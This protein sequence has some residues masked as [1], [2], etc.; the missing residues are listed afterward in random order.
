MKK[1]I[2][3]AV[4]LLCALLVSAQK[5]PGKPK[6]K[7][8]PLVTFV[9]LG[10]V[11][12]VPCKMMKPVMKEIEDIYGEKVEVIFYDVGQSKHKAMGDKYKVRV[13]P[14]Q[15][16]L[17]KDGKEFHRHEGFYPKDEIVKLIDK[18]LGI[19]RKPSKK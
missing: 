8:K 4:I 19:T 11:N 3:L 5:A 9:E 6:A 1:Y 13:I 16:F 14:T 2:V 17:D 7:P 12:C 10:S 18:Q 15:V